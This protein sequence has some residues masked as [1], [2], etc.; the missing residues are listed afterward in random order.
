MT[1]RFCLQDSQVW[2]HLVTLALGTRSLPKSNDQASNG[3]LD[4]VSTPPIIPP[5]PRSPHSPTTLSD[6]SPCPPL[7]AAALSLAAPPASAS[8]PP[9]PSPG[10]LPPLRAFL[11]VGRTLGRPPSLSVARSAASSSSEASTGPGPERE[12]DPEAASVR[13]AV[14]SRAPAAVRAAPVPPQPLHPLDCGRGTR[15]AST[16]RLR[17]PGRGP[18]GGERERPGGQM[19]PSAGNRQQFRVQLVPAARLLEEEREP[20]SGRAERSYRQVR[21][22][23]AGQ[24]A[25]RVRG[26]RAVREPGRPPDGRAAERLRGRRRP[27]PSPGDDALSCVRAR[28]PGDPQIHPQSPGPRR[29]LR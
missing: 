17:R 12:R 18:G 28:R 29:P 19:R 21:G 9:N 10:L 23:E 15:S 27:L 16:R 24:E 13:P 20:S 4:H 14:L 1:K 5:T 3:H 26:G 8:A 11:T 2:Q 25:G 6:F 7:R 22:R